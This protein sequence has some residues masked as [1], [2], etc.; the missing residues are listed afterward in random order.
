MAVSFRHKISANDGPLD[1]EFSTSM[2]GR[3][4][5]EPAT[6]YLQTISYDIERPV[7][8][9]DGTTV[10]IY[11]QTYHFGYSE[12]WGVSYVMSYELTARGGQWGMSETRHVEVTLTDIAFGFA[13]DSEQ[14][15]ASKPSP[16]TP[17][18]TANRF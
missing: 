2:T 17:G 16:Y 3:L 10:D 11:N 8:L 12:R 4:Q 7:K 18:P 6:G 13:G 15:L 9:A 5:L 1:M 14:D